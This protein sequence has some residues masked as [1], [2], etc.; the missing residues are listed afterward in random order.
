MSLT[1]LI[2]EWIS[3]SLAAYFFDFAVDIGL[4]KV[5]TFL[6]FIYYFINLVDLEIT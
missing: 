1:T 4:R 3:H 5:V 6:Y 2:I